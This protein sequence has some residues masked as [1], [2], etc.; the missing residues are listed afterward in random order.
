M[1]SR[2][3]PRLHSRCYIQLTYGF[4]TRPLMQCWIWPLTYPTPAHTPKQS[5]HCGGDGG[6]CADVPC[7]QADYGSKVAAA[8][9]RLES[10]YS[11]KV[12]QWVAHLMRSTCQ[13]AVGRTCLCV[14]VLPAASLLWLLARNCNRAVQCH[15]LHQQQPYKTAAMKLVQGRNLAGLWPALG[16]GH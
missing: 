8:E 14:L 16:A 1:R 7:R 13:A 11:D 5:Q 10:T 2:G 15:A 9:S 3:R 4:A 6:V 12:E